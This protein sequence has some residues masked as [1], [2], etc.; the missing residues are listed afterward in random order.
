MSF[1]NLLADGQSDARARIP[2]PPMQTLKH[3]EDSLD[4]VGLNADTVVSHAKGPFQVV[5]RG[6]YVDSR[7]HLFAEFDSVADQVLDELN[8]LAFIGQDSGKGIV[9]NQ[10]TTVL[11]GHFQIVDR[12]CQ[13]G[14]A[15]SGCELVAT[16]AHAGIGQQVVD[17][18]SHPLGPIHRVADEFVGVRIES[19]LVAFGQ[20]LHVARNHPKR[21]LQVMRGNVRELLQFDVALLQGLV[22]VA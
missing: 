4:V 17:E 1:H 11:N 2:L 16:P 15:V 14:L 13:D 21:L 22:R 10:G 18:G 8:E 12:S 9:C 7:R 3:P 19:P 20:Q 5:R 6:G